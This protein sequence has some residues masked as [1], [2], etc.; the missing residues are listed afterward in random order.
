MNPVVVEMIL[1]GVVFGAGIGLLV[2]VV[3]PT[4]AFETPSIHDALMVDRVGTRSALRYQEALLAGTPARRPGVLSNW[5]GRFESRVAVLRWSTPDV[6]LELVEWSRG[7][8]L[9]MKILMGVLGVLL[10]PLFWGFVFLL[11]GQLE[12]ALP[13]GVSF[14]LGVAL[15]FAPNLYVR[16]RAAARRLEMREALV[17]YLILL[18]LYKASGDGMVGALQRASAESEA[19]TF[20]R[21][22]ARVAAAIRAGSSP[23]SGIR[24]LGDELGIKDL[25]DVAEITMTASVEGAGVFTTLLARANG[26]RN[27]MQSNAEAGAAA[28]S[29]RLVIPKVML[30]FTGILFLL[31]PL[32][33]S[34]S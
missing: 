14:L 33:N 26:L 11:G 4:G 30:V 8:F 34:I 9:S 25:G 6:D 18:A 32:V 19:W 31:Y 7:R 23:Q 22:D 28:R 16:D 29:V 21:I 27:E 13:Q 10:G 15:F 24:A 20:R 12:Y 2:Q 17:S 3:A 5:A 1:A